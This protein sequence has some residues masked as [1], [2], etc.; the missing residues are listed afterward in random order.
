[1][2]FQ[3]GQLANPAYH[4]HRFGGGTLAMV[5]SEPKR[6]HVLAKNTAWFL[7]L[8]GDK[9]GEE[10]HEPVDLFKGVGK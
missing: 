3:K 6:S 10:V 7:W 9:A 4:R 1:M 2:E 5:V 8:N